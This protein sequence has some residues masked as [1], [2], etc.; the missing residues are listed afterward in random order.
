MT[1]QYGFELI[2]NRSCALRVA[3]LASRT[4]RAIFAPP[5]PQKIL[6]TFCLLS[7][8][9]SSRISADTIT[10]NAHKIDTSRRPPASADVQTTNSHSENARSPF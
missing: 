1:R 6:P 2:E 5:V 8:T 7:V 10:G 9:G 4:V 3:K